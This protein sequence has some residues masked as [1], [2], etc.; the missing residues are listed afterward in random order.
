MA[1]VEE[2]QVIVAVDVIPDI[3][4]PVIVGV[5]II[6]VVGVIGAVEDRE[7]IP[8]EQVIFDQHQI[9]FIPVRILVL[10]NI[11]RNI[12]ILERTI[13]YDKRVEM[14]GVDPPLPIL[15]G[16]VGDENFVNII[17]MY[18][19]VEIGEEAVDYPEVAP[20]LQFDRIIDPDELTV[21]DREVIS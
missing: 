2:V 20:I 10:I 7:V 11:Y 4:V 6:E 8:E 9:A 3:V 21:D 18:C 1:A 17:Q 16:R 14:I 15:E 5:V 12:E 13:L 19:I